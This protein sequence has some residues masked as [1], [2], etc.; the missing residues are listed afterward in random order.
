MSTPFR[1]LLNPL[2][3][4]V[5]IV[6]KAGKPTPD[7][8]R[9]WAQQ[10]A[11][12]PTIP[13][14][15]GTGIFVQTGPSTWALRTLEVAT[16]S[17][18]ALAITNG[19]G[20]AAD[21]VFVVDPTLIALAGLDTT[22]GFL[23]ETA[24]DSFTKRTLVAGTGI[25]ISNPT[26]AAGN[27][28]ISA[29]GSGDVVGPASA[30]DGDFVQFNTTT[31]KLIK[32]GGLSLDTDTTLAANSNSRIPSQQAVKAYVDAVAQGL[33]I[34]DSCLLA[35]AAALPSLVY[36][37]GSSGVGATL[38]G[39]AVGA[40]S[41]D[42][43]ALTVGNR[44]LVKNQATGFQNGIYVCTATGSGIA[45]FV[46]TRATDYDTSADIF[47]GT[48]TFIETGTANAAAGFVL[49][50]TGAITVGTTGLTFT[51]FSSAGGG[52]TQ[53]TG[54][55]TAGP[56]SGSQ[57]A[58]LA[59][60][61]VSAGSYTNANITVD[62][63]GRLTSAST[64]SGGGGASGAK[65]IYGMSSTGSAVSYAANFVVCMGV[66]VPNGGTIDRI[67][68]MAG[69]PASATTKWR[70][71]VYSMSA[72]APNTLLASSNLVTGMVVGA[73]IV[74]LTSSYTNT[75]GSD[76]FLYVCIA[77][78]TANFNALVYS[79]SGGSNLWNNGGSTLPSTAPATSV[80]GH[81]WC[82]FGIGSGGT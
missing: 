23:V 10:R 66:V 82:I 55:V 28:T 50:T 9:A 77:T 31:G 48:F 80:D 1:T 32:D 40:L 43:T 22:P 39:V 52:I 5:P 25:T 63:K 15:G 3:W 42:G 41:I 60:S 54:D 53:L 75:S 58:T 4:N 29:T 62:A 20:V 56:G 74:A 8:L 17:A 73:N 27:P 2:F 12:N 34:R 30:V 71:G 21:P 78:D 46:L 59:T 61:G 76:V 72:G 36:S 45:V 6:D 57:A 14:A 7:F 38:T 81:G 51:Q 35:T 65:I 37:N 79:S 19:D 70:G 64:G 49:V 13:L 47:A 67:G 33:S 44:V 69:G 68:V 16:V 18:P 26:G 11:I 24:A